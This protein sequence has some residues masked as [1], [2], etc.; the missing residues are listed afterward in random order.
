MRR[1]FRSASA[2]TSTDARRRRLS[3]EVDAVEV[4]VA[5]PEEGDTLVKG[6]DADDG[7]PTLDGVNS[8]EDEEKGTDAEEDE[9]D[10]SSALSDKVRPISTPA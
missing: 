9:L 4:E 5:R 1:S 3:R 7:T 8:A 2:M 6:D 10:L